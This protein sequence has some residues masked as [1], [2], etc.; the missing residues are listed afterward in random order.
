MNDHIWH[1]LSIVY[2]STY[3]ENYGNPLLI[4]DVCN[5]IIS[6]LTFSTK[7]W[8]LLKSYYFVKISSHMRSLIFRPKLLNS[9]DYMPISKGIMKWGKNLSF[10]A[11]S[12]FLALAKWLYSFFSSK[13]FVALIT[14][15]FKYS[16]WT[17]WLLKRFDF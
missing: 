11:Y 14:K 2:V 15:A 17:S 1:Q 4:I 12:Y 5:V 9:G 6:F 7:C 16:C 8:L 3:F 13:I 10:L